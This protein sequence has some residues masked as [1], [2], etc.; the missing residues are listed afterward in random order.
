[1]TLLACY[2]P[3]SLVSGLIATGLQ[4]P[5]V[6]FLWAL[7]ALIRLLTHSGLYTLK[8]RDIQQAVKDSFRKYASCLSVWNKI[9]NGNDLYTVLKCMHLTRLQT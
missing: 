6:F 3:L 5:A 9:H 2:L 1:M 8:M 4:T 7:T